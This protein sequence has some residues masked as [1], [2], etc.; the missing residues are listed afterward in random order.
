MTDNLNYPLDQLCTSVLPPQAE[1]IAIFLRFLLPQS[2]PDMLQEVRFARSLR[3]TLRNF[4]Q[5]AFNMT[6]KTNH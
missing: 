2:P 4:Q 5:D 3:R 6:D 1:Q